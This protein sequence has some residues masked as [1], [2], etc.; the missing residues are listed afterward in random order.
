MNK[1]LGKETK[2]EIIDCKFNLKQPPLG[3][4]KMSNKHKLNGQKK[5]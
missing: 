2:L 5:N 1:D 3:H 4:T